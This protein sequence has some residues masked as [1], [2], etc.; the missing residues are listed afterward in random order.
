MEKLYAQIGESWKKGDKVKLFV[1]NRYDMREVGGSKNE[2]VKGIAFQTSS[3]LGGSNIQFVM[4]LFLVIGILSFT[5]M[6][7]VM[8]A[9]F[10]NSCE[11]LGTF[12]GFMLPQIRVDAHWKFSFHRG[13]SPLEIQISGEMD[14]KNIPGVSQHQEPAAALRGELPGARLAGPAVMPAGEESGFGRGLLWRSRL[15]DLFPR[16]CSLSKPPSKW[17]GLLLHVQGEKGEFK[18]I[19]SDGARM[20]WAFRAFIVMH[21]HSS[22]S[23]V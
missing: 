9:H 23:K 2:I 5:I 18:H 1:A 12:F 4:I 3:A 16:C 10:K 22:P 19:Q 20:P 14:P 6:F 17:R 13:E 11:T 7:V 8:F 21:I 15:C